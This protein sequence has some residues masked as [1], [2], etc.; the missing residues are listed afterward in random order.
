MSKDSMSPALLL[1]LTWNSLRSTVRVKPCNLFRSAANR[2]NSRCMWLHS[3]M[4]QSTYNMRSIRLEIQHSRQCGFRTPHL[5]TVWVLI[6]LPAFP[7]L[8]AILNPN[9]IYC[10][11]PIQPSIGCYHRHW[12]CECQY[13]QRE[14]WWDYNEWKQSPKRCTGGP[15]IYGFEPQLNGG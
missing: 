5:H 13:H 3:G 15:N 7:T 6:H 8:L 1:R 2:P 14:W 9:E 10:R 12:S 4:S 11:F